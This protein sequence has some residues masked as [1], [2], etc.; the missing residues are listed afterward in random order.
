MSVEFLLEVLVNEW[1]FETI[2]ENYPP[3]TT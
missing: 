3:V 2:L 1:T